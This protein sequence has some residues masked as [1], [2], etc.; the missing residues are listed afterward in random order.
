MSKDA[1]L[2]FRTKHTKPPRRDL[3]GEGCEVLIFSEIWRFC[4]Q[5]FPTNSA[6]NKE[7][8]FSVICIE[9]DF[10]MPDRLTMNE[11]AVRDST[12]LEGMQLEA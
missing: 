2:I 9:F 11:G 10:S 7:S 8:R 6:T 1:Q 12:R 5:V 4:I 3:E